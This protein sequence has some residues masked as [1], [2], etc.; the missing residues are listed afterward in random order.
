MC[1][2]IL[3]RLCLSSTSTF[4]AVRNPPHQVEYVEDVQAVF[5][6]LCHSFP[7]T[8]TRADEVVRLKIHPTRVDLA[9]AAAAAAA[10]AVAFG[11]SFQ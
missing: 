10:A 9:T 11:R 1:Y 8:L 7:S 5:P 6:G 2:P 4:N 3:L